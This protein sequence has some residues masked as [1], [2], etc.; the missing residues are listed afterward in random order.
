MDLQASCKKSFCVKIDSKIKLL[1]AFVFIPSFFIN[2]NNQSTRLVCVASMF[3]GSNAPI[4]QTCS[5]TYSSFN[6]D[7]EVHERLLTNSFRDYS[8]NQT[9]KKHREKGKSGT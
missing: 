7:F 4:N 9:H 8:Q 3:P 1:R 5:S 2:V 6:A